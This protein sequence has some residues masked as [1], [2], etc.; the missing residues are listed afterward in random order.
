M[1]INLMIVNITDNVNFSTEPVIRKPSINPM[2]I[3]SFVMS[4]DNSQH[5][6]ATM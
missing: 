2:A 4:C 5:I 3:T 6:P 1:T